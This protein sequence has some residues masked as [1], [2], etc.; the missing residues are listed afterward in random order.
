MN[1]VV[2]ITVLSIS[3]GTTNE[4]KRLLDAKCSSFYFQSLERFSFAHERKMTIS[5]VVVVKE[6]KKTKD[7][8][9]ATN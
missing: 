1:I 7:L 2:L 3:L 9:H 4:S 8:Q 5:F 6:R